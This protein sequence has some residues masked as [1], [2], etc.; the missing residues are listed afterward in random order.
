MSE[1]KVPNSE[2]V[3][4]FNTFS[5]ELRNRIEALI[6]QVLIISGGIQT[7]T[8]SAFLAASKPELSL[9]T[10]HLLKTAWFQLSISIVLCLTLMLLQILAMAHVG[11]KFKNKLENPPEG[12]AVMAAW[13]PL[14]ITNWV[15][16]AAAF[17]FCISGVFTISKAAASLISA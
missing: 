12:V 13:L 3:N 6:K 15:V 17:G 1:D 16:G 8:I 14:R 2:S 7:I 4:G 5:M 10:V 11:Y 9:A